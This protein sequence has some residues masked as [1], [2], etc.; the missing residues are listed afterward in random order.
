MLSSLPPEV[1]DHVVY[2]IRRQ[3]AGGELW[4]PRTYSRVVDLLDPE[5]ARNYKHRDIA[6]LSVTEILQVDESAIREALAAPGPPLPPGDSV[7]S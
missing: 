1:H 3:T 7:R 6:N 4:I 2:G 5:S